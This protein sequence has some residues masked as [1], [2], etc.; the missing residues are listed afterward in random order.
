MEDLMAASDIADWWDLQHRE[1]EKILSEFV[2]DNPQWWAIGVATA[3]ST[4][5]AL[6]AGFVDILRFGEGMAEG[7]WRGYGKDAL[8]LVGLLGP[9]G[10]V[11]G[12]AARG[13]SVLASRLAVQTAGTTG[14]CTFSAINAALKMISGGLRPNMFQTVDDAA[15]ATGLTPAAQAGQGAWLEQLIPFL[16]KQ[17]VPIK[18]LGFANT[19]DD[20]ARALTGERGVIV[21]SVEWVN[22][23][24]V[25]VGHTIY[26]VKNAAG[27]VRFAHYGGKLFSSVEGLIKSAYGAQGVNGLK[28]SKSISNTLG[29]MVLFKRLSLVE[30]LEEGTRLAWKVVPV[31]LA[32]FQDESQPNAETAAAVKRAFEAKLLSK[33]GKPVTKLPAAPVKASR[34]PPVAYL[35]GV[36]YRL[37]HLGYGAGPVDG[38]NGPRTRKAIIRFQTDHHGD[39]FKLAIDG[40]PGP[41]TQAALAAICGY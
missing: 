8:R 9:L 25:A 17:G 19:F 30:T 18:N 22:N 35:T 21:F 23:A 36:Q 14:P 2:E 34:V 24:N 16:V 33:K 38:I 12:Y 31:A 20:V 10:K 3:A 7:G 6:G 26:A 37:N 39:Q 5:M 4:S 29:Q 40:I 27:Q 32:L 41:L 13:G 1:S 15:R 11:G 28:I